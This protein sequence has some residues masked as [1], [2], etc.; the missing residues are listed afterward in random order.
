MKRTAFMIGGL[1]WFLFSLGFGFLLVLYVAQGA[2]LQFFGPPV[3]SGSV[4]IGLVH[5]TGFVTA[6][7]LCFVIGAGLCAHAVI[8]DRRHGNAK[9]EPRPQ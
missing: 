7:V 8:P 6:S 5:L 9:G 1:L 4:L 2:G 3:S